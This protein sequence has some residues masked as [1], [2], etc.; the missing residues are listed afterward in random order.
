MHQFGDLEAAQK[1]EKWI[2]EVYS[3]SVCIQQQIRSQ[4]GLKPCYSVGFAQCYTYLG[5]DAIAA[6]DLGFA[7]AGCQPASNAISVAASALEKRTESL[8]SM[9]YVPQSQPPKKQVSPDLKQREGSVKPDFG[10]PSKCQRALI[11]CLR[12]TETDLMA[13][14]PKDAL[15]VLLAGRRKEVENLDTY[16]FSHRLS[17]RPSSPPFPQPK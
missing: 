9:M 10:P 17:D 3:T 6:R 13:C 11:F 4:S 14:H 8:Q 1:L 12:E 5:A 16:V 7:M 2:S 15:P